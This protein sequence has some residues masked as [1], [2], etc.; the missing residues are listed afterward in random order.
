MNLYRGREI[1]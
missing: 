1:Q